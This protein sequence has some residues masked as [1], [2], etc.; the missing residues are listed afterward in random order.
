MFLVMEKTPQCLTIEEVAKE[1]DIVKI[2]E[3]LS[4]DSTIPNVN[5]FCFD[6]DHS[7]R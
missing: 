7:I 1:K 4:N 6:G 5:D 3:H 2:Q